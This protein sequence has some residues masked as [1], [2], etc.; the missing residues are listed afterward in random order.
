MSSSV[1]N[2]VVLEYLISNCCVVHLI[3]KIC[4]RCHLKNVF[5]FTSFTVSMKP[6]PNYTTSLMHHSRCTE[7]GSRV[8]AYDLLVELSSGCYNNFELITTQLISMH[9]QPDPQIA[10]EWEVC[11][12][13][14]T[15]LFSE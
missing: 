15:Q 6:L 4:L 14:F 12:C 1:N 7:I 8:A 11:V 5:K 9:H 13:L 2:V 10:K 3:T